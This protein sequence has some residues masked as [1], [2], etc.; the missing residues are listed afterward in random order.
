MSFGVFRVGLVLATV[1]AISISAYLGYLTWDKE[2]APVLAIPVEAARGASPSLITSTVSAHTEEINTVAGRL[3]ITGGE[4]IYGFNQ[5]FRLNGRVVY[6]SGN[7][8][9]GVN[10]IF[11]IHGKTVILLRETLNKPSSKSA[12][13]TN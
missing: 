2:E 10:K 11:N 6:D 4:G 13:A 8:G 12:T 7:T 9:V 1:G 3:E 5:Q